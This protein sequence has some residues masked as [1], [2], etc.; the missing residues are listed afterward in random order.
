MI[1]CH[2]SK[3]ASRSYDPASW[4]M[5]PRPEPMAARGQAELVLVRVLA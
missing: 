2:Y 4:G 5:E 1:D 3:L